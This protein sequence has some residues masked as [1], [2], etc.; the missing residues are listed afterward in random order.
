M[1]NPNRLLIKIRRSVNKNLRD[2]INNQKDTIIPPVPEKFLPSESPLRSLY[3]EIYYNHY[4][5]LSYSAL[6]LCNIFLERLT[7]ILYRHFKPSG[8]STEWGTIIPELKAFFNGSSLVDKNNLVIL[9][10]DFN[11]YRDKIRNL[12]LHGKIEE[13]LYSTVLRYK[14][15]NVM[16]LQREEI[17]LNYDPN[18]NSDK[19]NK[20][21]YDRMT[22]DTHNLFILISVVLHTFKNYIKDEL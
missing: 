22:A 9:M 14:A 8:K 2:V 20:I 4:A 21:L 1:K 11:Y 3:N 18:I 16:N 19:K 13:Y 10:D 6:S 12:V 17:K 15:I 5:G 7:R